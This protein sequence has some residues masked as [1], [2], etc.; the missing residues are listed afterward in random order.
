M[1]LRET[2]GLNWK[3]AKSYDVNFSDQV[4]VL[5]IPTP[6]STT[7]V[8]ETAKT[9]LVSLPSAQTAARVKYTR[10]CGIRPTQCLSSSFFSWRLSSIS[11]V[12]P[13]SPSSTLSVSLTFSSVLVAKER[14]QKT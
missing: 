8:S 1:N 3:R 4:S 9:H 14:F 12:P 2:F 13:S 7:P 10:K 6:P 5:S 11:R